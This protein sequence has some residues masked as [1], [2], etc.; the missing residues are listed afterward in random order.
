MQKSLSCTLKPDSHCNAAAG[1]PHLERAA[2]PGDDGV[3]G[4]HKDHYADP[5]KHGR[6]EDVPEEVQ[7]EEHL[8]GRRP[9]H[10]DVDGELHEALGV[11]CHKV[12][13]LPD[14]CVLASHAAQSQ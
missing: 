7:A 4:D 8:E 5:G 1:T 10:A 2:A 3:D 9:D 13:D 14:S 12:H 6:T 11:H